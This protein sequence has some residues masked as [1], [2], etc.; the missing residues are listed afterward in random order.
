M[1]LSVLAWGSELTLI[2]KAVAELKT[3]PKTE[4]ETEPILNIEL[5]A[6]SVYE[7]REDRQKLA[8]CIRS[9]ENADI[10][11]IHPSGES[12]WDGII[13]AFPEKTPVVS[14]GYSDTFLS[15]STVPVSVISAVSTYILYGGEENFKH[16]LSYCAS[17]ILGMNIPY[18]APVPVHWEGIFHPCA[19]IVFETTEEYLSW[20]TKKHD[21]TVG[22][23]FPRTQWICDDTRIVAALITELEKFADVIPVFCFGISDDVLGSHS[24]TEV[25]ETYFRGK[26]DAII[27]L[28]SFINENDRASYLKG[29]KNA[30]VPVFHPLMLYHKTEEQWN[31][32]TAGMDGTEIG[33]TVAMPEFQGMTEMITIGVAEEGSNEAAEFGSHVPVEN[34]VKKIAGR[35]KKWLDLRSKT[36]SERK[37]AFVLHNKPCASVEATVGAG[38]HLDT[39][40]SVV[41][42][43]KEMKS[44][45][46]SVKHPKTGEELVGMI[47]ERKA[48]SEFRWTSVEE[49]VKKGG[50]LDLVETEE[51]N[52]W[53]FS[54]PEG[55]QE[56]VCRAW[57][58][59]PGEEIDG[60]PPG[61]IYDGKIVVTGIRLGNAVVCVQPKRGCLGSRCDGRACRILHDPE[62]PPTHQY[63]ATYHYLEETFGADVI[64]HVGTHGNLEFLPGKNVAL[65]DECFPDIA[66]GTMPH[67]YIYNSDNPPE[68]T[69]AKR[70]AYATIIDHM[71]TVMTESGLYAELKELE[72]QISDYQRAEGTDMARAHALTHTI[73]ELIIQ[74]GIAE[75]IGL[76]EM[77]KNKT[78]FEEI[79]SA[80]HRVITMMYNT[81]IPDGMHIFGEM[82]EGERLTGFIHT[83]LRYNG[84]V[85]EC[86]LQMT[87][88]DTP[89]SEAD[90]RLLLDIDTAGKAL[91][92]AI[93][94]GCDPVKSAYAILGERLVR[95]DE[96]GLLSIRDAV[97]DISSRIDASEEIKS[98]LHAIDA[99]FVEPGPSGLIT[100]GN[101][102]VLPTGRNF[103]SLDPF[104]VPTKAAWRIG[105]RLA[106]EVISK[107]R[108]EFNAY[109]ENI[110]FYWMASDI[111]WADGEQF[112]QL[113]ALIGAE[114]VWK[115]G[116]VRSYRLLTPE[117]LGRPRIDVTVRT[118]GILRD[119]FYS[120]IEILDD[121]ICEVAAL[122]EPE[123]VNYIRKHTTE[124][125]STERI[126]GARPGTY[127][128]G[129]SLAVYSSSWKEE[130]DLADVFVRWNSY[131]YGRDNYGQLSEDGLTGQLQTV[132]LSFNKTVTDEYDLLGCCCYFGTHGGLTAASRHLSHKEIPVYYGDTRDQ[133]KIEVRTI[134][135]EIRRVVTTKLLNPKWISGM[136]RH[137]YKGAGD[138]SGRITHLYGWEATTQEVD[139]RIFDDVTRT[140]VLDEEMREF[141]EEHNPWALEEIGRRLLEAEGRGLWNADPD[142]LSGLR[143]AYLEIEGCIEERTGDM[144][145]NIQG[146]SIDVYL[147]QKEGND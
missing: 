82:P 47:L 60:V 18:N 71:Q 84:L 38:A 146:G 107:Y 101:T 102:D 136:R 37:I 137:G 11:L 138:I 105:I 25:I 53:F 86:I 1:K 113:L 19:E 48:I 120:C 126:F 51:Y 81:Q 21:R 124:S 103:Y 94:G 29:I 12:Y 33:W 41:R 80:A 49:I 15:A 73:P 32:S 135:D 87:G 130:A 65:S 95:P 78:P 131:S 57:G 26:T 97:L 99:G 54:L 100:G 115:N 76:E 35:V 58:R 40:E 7:L 129:V 96:E 16:M 66:I 34:R 13:E 91:I 45:G 139:D 109:P 6:W 89:V 70:R 22:I 142:V 5:S 111:M 110:A 14:F 68:G 56:K 67:L 44:E 9:F 30:D 90:S 52:K 39:T 20:Y 88:S 92:E 147:P 108:A 141:F 125:G 43:L 64:I 17:E 8:E 132:D 106:D 122:D 128:N 83:V 116:K 133:N 75:T 134:A 117:E 55:V 112:A 27:D 127:G 143:E 23:L 77:M 2:S 63:L 24:G 118:S 123:E 121:A 114:P 74:A 42:I 36:P 79:V 98:L 144:E 4:S 62:I 85:R 28:R 31:S 3:E 46:Y 119:N 61:M 104:R 145:G 140:F 10:I 59:P 93:L 72:E 69:T 50:A